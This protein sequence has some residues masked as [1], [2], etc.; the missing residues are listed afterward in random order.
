MLRR[1]RSVRTNSPM[2]EQRTHWTKHDAIYL[3]LK[4]YLLAFAG[5][6]CLFFDVI[7]A[8]EDRLKPAS[9][10]SALVLVCVL[11]A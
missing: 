2:D 5:R 6:V 9:L 4:P 3:W 1:V 10:L 7:L 11:L 8:S